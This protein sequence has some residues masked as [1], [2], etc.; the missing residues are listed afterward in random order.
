MSSSDDQRTCVRAAA[1]QD[2]ADKAAGG[3]RVRTLL[4][5]ESMTLSTRPTRLTLL[6]A[7]VAISVCGAV[8]M[9]GAHGA[10]T[11]PSYRVNKVMLANG[12]AGTARWSTCD[13]PIRYSVDTRALHTS[14]KRQER[15]VADVKRTFREVAAATGFQFRYTAR[16][17]ENLPTLRSYRAR[18]Q[19][20]QVAFMSPSRVDESTRVLPRVNPATGTLPAAWTRWS[21]H[22]ATTATGAPASRIH[23]AVIAVDADQYKEHPWGYRT[24]RSTG[25]LLL[26]EAGH[27]MGLDHVDSQSEIMFGGR[28]R[29]T[30]IPAAAYQAGD[31]T[32]LRL[33]GSGNGCLAG[34]KSQHR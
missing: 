1:A 7:A 28:I 32:G 30:L 15:A 18:W 12:S 6:A 10:T 13:R 21:G 17:P 2:P 4:H 11:D 29:D 19:R 25:T 16:T 31:L 3:F 24:P 14:A 22:P 23:A 9:A 5:G 8:G 20:I 33:V 26:H 34:A 27:A